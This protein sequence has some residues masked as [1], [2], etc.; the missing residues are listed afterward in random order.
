MHLFAQTGNVTTTEGLKVIPFEYYD[1]STV[2]TT[3]MLAWTLTL[4]LIPAVTVGTVALV[5]LLRRRR[6]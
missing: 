3:Q 6:A 1:I 4:T 5:V 2:T